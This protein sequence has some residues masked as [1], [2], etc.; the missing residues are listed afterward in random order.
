MPSAAL[1]TPPKPKRPLA[2]DLPEDQAQ[3]AAAGGQ[4]KSPEDFGVHN[5]SGI[6]PLQA[7]A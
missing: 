5:I 3:E 6:P 7:Y 1:L 2:R 4:S